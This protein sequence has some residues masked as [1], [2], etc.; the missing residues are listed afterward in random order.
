M[1]LTKLTT[2]RQ[3]KIA[4][5]IRAGNSKECAAQ[6]AGISRSSL[7]GWLAKGRKSKS[8]IFSDFLDAIEKA[9]SEAE[10]FHVAN[11]MM[12]AKSGT[13]Q[14]SAWWLERVKSERYGRRQAIAHSKT[15]TQLSPEE[16]A[17]L[18]DTAAV[19]ASDGSIVWKRQ[20]LLLEK[21]YRSGEIDSKFYFQMMTQLTTG[22]TRLAELQ[23]RGDGPGLPN[24]QIEFH[25]SD[26]AIGRPKDQ[27]ITITATE[28][29]GD[30]IEVA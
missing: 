4:S 28:N 18:A 23:L 11:I 3:E 8:G 15:P 25:M 1:G 26:P 30:L 6:V 13:W 14:A 2:S 12:A 9:E 21:A 7:Y 5:L 16:N 10:A 27:P 24:V 29:C 22:A 20:L 17:A 19:N